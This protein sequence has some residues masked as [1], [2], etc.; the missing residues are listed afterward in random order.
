MNRIVK[1]HLS[2]LEF[3]FCKGI[4]A[5]HLRTAVE[6]VEKFDITFSELEGEEN[7]V[8]IWHINIQYNTKDDKVDKIKHVALFSVKGNEVTQ[9]QEGRVWV[10]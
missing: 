10:F 6:G 1:S 4:I 2:N 3:L 7:N 9:F 8:N 5:E